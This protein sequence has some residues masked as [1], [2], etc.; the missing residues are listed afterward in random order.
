MRILFLCTGNSCRSQ[1]AEGIARHY[2]GP[3]V[4]ACSAG[5][6][7]V[8][9]N[10]LAVEVM[11]EKGIDISGQTSKAMDGLK[12]VPDVVI[13]LCGDPHETCATY[14]GRA[15]IIHWPL[16]DPARAQGSRET[17]LKVFREV[18]DEIEARVKA[19]LGRM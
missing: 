18:R 9:V 6:A 10:P 11:R 14:P 4:E 1:M 7:P 19:L 8:G 16:R 15:K 13:T 2:G 17:V 5:L 3:G 12:V